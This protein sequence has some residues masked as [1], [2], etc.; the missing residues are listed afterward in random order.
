MIG[1]LLFDHNRANSSIHKDYYTRSGV[2]KELYE[3]YHEDYKKEDNIM[4]ILEKQVF[5]DSFDEETE[6]I[7]WDY[8][9][10]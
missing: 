1:H 6:P 2:Y 5:Y 9:D 4:D 7:E 3:T 10:K 8:D